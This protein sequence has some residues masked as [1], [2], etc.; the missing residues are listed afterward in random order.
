MESL[1]LCDENNT[2]DK[3]SLEAAWEIISIL[4]SDAGERMNLNISLRSSLM[5][6]YMF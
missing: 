2:N 5:F 6:Q 4:T 3:W 1:H